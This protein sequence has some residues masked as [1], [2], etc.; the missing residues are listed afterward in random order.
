V[1]SPEP[2]P[3]P[4]PDQPGW[5]AFATYTLTQIDD[6]QPGQLVT[7]ANPDGIVIGL[8]RFH[9]TTT[10]TLNA[11]GTYSLTLE[12][13]DDKVEFLLTDEGRFTWQPVEGGILLQMSSATFGD[14]FLAAASPDLSAA[15]DY[16]FDGDGSID[17][18]FGF[19][20]VGG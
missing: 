17:T 9:P 5:N 11:D 4:G 14:A 1:P 16:D 13:T 10:L 3:G 12:Y 20:Q 18:R 6:G 19:V 8:Y 15:I 2:G 7:L